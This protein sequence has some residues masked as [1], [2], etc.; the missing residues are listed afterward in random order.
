MIWNIEKI[1]FMKMK[2]CFIFSFLLTWTEKKRNNVYG[3]ATTAK[4]MNEWELY[5]KFVHIYLLNM[6]ILQKNT[7]KG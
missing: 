4:N 6:E 1:F 7:K 3:V 5:R 2:I